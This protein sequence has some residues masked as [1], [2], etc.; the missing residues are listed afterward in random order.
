MTNQPYN[1]WNHRRRDHPMRPLGDAFSKY[2]RLGDSSIAAQQNWQT[3]TFATVDGRKAGMRL[4]VEGLIL[5][6]TRNGREIKHTIRDEAGF[7]A[8]LSWLQRLPGY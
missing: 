2:V 6:A 8:G 5:A 4:R 7:A 1:Q 3:V